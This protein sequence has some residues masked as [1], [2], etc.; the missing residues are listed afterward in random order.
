MA[1]S[2]HATDAQDTHDALAAA[3]TTIVSAPAHGPF[4][5]TFRFADPDGL[6]FITGAGSGGT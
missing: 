5:R 1:V 2:L 4:G 3:G 6:T